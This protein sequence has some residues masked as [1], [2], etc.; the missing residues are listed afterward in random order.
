MT[1]QGLGD[2]NRNLIIDH[3]H[4]LIL[5]EEMLRI[6]TGFQGIERI[7]GRLRP[8]EYSG[9][10]TDRDR[11]TNSEYFAHGSPVYLR[12]AAAIYS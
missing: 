2:A 1:M 5:E 10:Q 7:V 3:A 9:G 11:E 8:R 12:E 6:F 4:E